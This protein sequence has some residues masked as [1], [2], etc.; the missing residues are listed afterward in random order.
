MKGLLLALVCAF[1]LTPCG[2][3]ATVTVNLY[4]GIN[5]ITPPVIAQNPD[6]AVVFAGFAIDNTLMRWDT[7]MWSWVDYDP[8]DPGIFGSVREGV[9]YRL[10]VAADTTIGF[11]GSPAAS[12]FQIS[13]PHEGENWIGYPYRDPQPLANL[14]VRY[15]SATKTWSDAHLAG[16]VDVLCYRFDGQWQALVDVGP[17]EEFPTETDLKV[18][19]AYRVTT[20]QDN[21]VL[22]ITDPNPGPNPDLGHPMTS[23]WQDDFTDNSRDPQ[24]VQ[25]GGQ[26][27]GCVSETNAQLEIT[28]PEATGTPPWTSAGY[29]TRTALRGDCDVQ[30]DFQLLTWIPECQM[31]ACLVLYTADPIAS[32]SAERANVGGGT[33]V[34]GAN[35]NN[36][37]YIETSTSDTSGK[38]RITRTGV[39]VRS[40][41]WN[42]A[43][44]TWVLIHQANYCDSRPLYAQVF[45]QGPFG[46]K[47]TKVAFDNFK[48]TGQFDAGPIRTWGDN[49]YNQCDPLPSPNSHFV[50]VAGGGDH[51]LGLRSDGSIAAWGSNSDYQCSPLPSPNS[52]FVAVAAG[53]CH[54][55]G[56]QYDGSVRAWGDNSWGKSTPPGYG[57]F[58]AIGAGCEHSLGL[59]SDGSIVAWGAGQPGQTEPPR[60][61]QCAVPSPNSS[62]VAIAAGDYHSLGLKA[63]GSIVAWGAGQPGQTGDYHYGQCDVPTPNS[64]FVA[65]AAGHSH[66]LGLKSDGRIVAWGNNVDHQCDAPDHGGFVAIAAGSIH[67]LGLK[68]DGSIVAWGHQGDGKCTVPSPNS[69]FVAISVGSIHSLGLKLTLSPNDDFA[70]A[71]TISGASGQTTGSNVDATKE[72]GE[73]NHANGSGSKSVWW[74]WTAPA[75]GCA[76]VSANDVGGGSS[77]GGTSIAVYTGTSVNSLTEVVSNPSMH[78]PTVDFGATAGTT[79]HIAVDVANYS[80]GGD[81]VLNWSLGAPVPNDDFADATVISGASGQT[82]GSNVDATKEEPDEPDHA[83]NPGGKSVWWRWTAP[84]SGC[85]TIDTFGSDFDTLLA[86]YVNDTPLQEVVS[87]D[88]SLNHSPQS[89]VGFCATGGTT[90]YIAVDGCV[91]PGPPSGSIVL[92]WSLLTAP[93]NDSFANASVISSFTGGTLTLTANNAC[94][95]KELDELDHQSNEGGKSLWW[96]W[97]PTADTPVTIDTSG[98]DFDTL[99]AVYTGNSVDDLDPVADT[100]ELF[101]R[102]D[103]VGFTATAG[104][105]YR[106]AVDGKNSGSGAAS[107][108]IALSMHG[109]TTDIAATKLLPDQT[110]VCVGP[111]VATATL[112]GTYDFYIESENRTSGIQVYNNPQPDVGDEVLIFGA[113]IRNMYGERYIYAQSV[114]VLSSGNPLP[115]PLGMP[116]RSLG[117]GDWNYNPTTGAGQKGVTGGVGLNNIGLRVRVWGRLTEYDLDPNH[118][119][120][121]WCKIDDGLG[122]TVKVYAPYFYSDGQYVTVT[123][124]SSVEYESGELKRVIRAGQIID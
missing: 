69:R 101:G 70:D 66:S 99:L 9:A 77:G 7:A 42:S 21:V 23:Y 102:V 108:N 40:Y 79:Y 31:R 83:G 103:L 121:E 96:N 52:G 10:Q 1:L 25:W 88:G 13:I 50:A 3:S 24:W 34:Y 26:Y 67:S 113:L 41:Y 48:M 39:W 90:Y 92:N 111:M 80:P 36:N 30:V 55:L 27:V 64:G 89:C 38:L 81:I 115:N 49:D 8:G 53:G 56:L 87:N 51:S 11:V 17:Q 18:G 85:V 119:P 75:D 68:S 37:G 63:N 46:K 112:P 109:P 45:L 114:N 94:A 16:W 118:Y 20:L 60:F 43:T 95:T 124:F 122:S 6:P 29:C 58:V 57:G 105:T 91:E 5:V 19:A 72:Q 22:I 14:Q 59:Q 100:Y 93:P 107:G 116:L 98:S 62:F 15:G 97:I 76:T 74:R 32:Y 123:G 47:L 73:W 104:L 110:G 12:P 78:F 4:Q 106:I 117:G 35:L 84:A 61:G 33:Q 120:A 28:V 71:I 44:S 86:V 2:A 65:I 54:S 82:T